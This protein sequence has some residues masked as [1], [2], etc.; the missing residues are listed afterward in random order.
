MYA[1]R[2]AKGTRFNPAGLTA[3]IAINAAFVAALMFSVPTLIAPPH[4]DDPLTTY[5]VPPVK[6]PP[7]EKIEKPVTQ[8]NRPTEHITTPIPTVPTNPTTDFTATTDPSPPVGPTIGADP[9]VTVID[10]PL[11]PPPM[12]FIEPAVDARYARDF[13]PIYPAAERR[14]EREGRVSI[15]V[16][17]GIDGRV[18][19]A[20]RLAA[21]SDAFWQVTLDR[22]LSKWRFKPATRGGIP[23]EAWRTMSL[24]FVLEG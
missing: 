24:T 1:D 17:I 15:R 12:T 19:E 2:N 9:G 13:Q 11:P 20:K 16:L 6:P 10:P 7:P 5:T 21:T 8:V 22:A 3:A 4:T 14:A 18:K 23:V